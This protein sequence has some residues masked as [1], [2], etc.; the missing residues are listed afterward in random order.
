MKKQIIT[1]ILCVGAI[2]TLSLSGCGNKATSST[3][4]TP[5]QSSAASSTTTESTESSHTDSQEGLGQITIIPTENLPTPSPTEAPKGA[6][7]IENVDKYCF[8]GFGAVEAAGIDEKQL[9]ADFEWHIQKV[10]GEGVSV[11]RR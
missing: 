3:T 10:Y 9:I 11:I 5:V 6:E 8:S 1:H 7:T 2:L 4:S